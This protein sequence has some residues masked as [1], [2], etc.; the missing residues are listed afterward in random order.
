MNRLH[1]L[2]L[3]ECIISAGSRP[4]CAG[5]FLFQMAAKQVEQQ[6]KR[7]HYTSSEKESSSEE[8][9]PKELP[10]KFRRKERSDKIEELTAIIAEIRDRMDKLEGKPYKA[11]ANNTDI[12]QKLK[13]IEEKIDNL[14]KS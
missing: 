7:K 13:A 14:T 1:K 5:N 4:L 3:R 2:K 9:P 6:K 11:N 8:E 12:M 10:R